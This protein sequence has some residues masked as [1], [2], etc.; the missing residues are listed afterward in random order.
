M[1]HKLTIVARG[2]SL[3]NHNFLPGVEAKTALP[4]KCK[5]FAYN[6]STIRVVVKCLLTTPAPFE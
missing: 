4:Q 2:T 5:M 1:D 6:T 3:I